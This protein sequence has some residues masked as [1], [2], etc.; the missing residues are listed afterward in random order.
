MNKIVLNVLAFFFVAFTTNAFSAELPANKFAKADQVKKGLFTVYV[1]GSNYFFEIPRRLMGRDFLLGS[2]IAE[3]SSVE[4]RSNLV[5]GQRLYDPIL[6]R[7]SE[8]V[9]KL[10]L[11]RPD[12]EKECA[13]EDP[14]FASFSLNNR[15][16]V[17]ETFDIEQRTDSSVFINVTKFFSDDLPAVE[18]FNEKSKP[19]KPILKLNGILRAES[20]PTNVEFTVRNA[21]ETTKEPFLVILQKS[22]IL[23]PEKPVMGRFSDE[24]MGYDVVNK[25]FYS[26]KK[27]VEKGSYITRFNLYPKDLKAYLRGELVE[28]VKPIVFYVD[29]SFPENWRKA[30]VKGIEDWQQAFEAVGF[31]N[32]IVARE[33]PK[34]PHF[35]PNDSRYN[36]FK[37]AV[38]NRSNAQGV[39]W[40]DPRSGEIVQAEVLFYSNI[41]ALLHKWYFL[42]TAAVN[43]AARKKELD[44]ETMEKLIRYSAAHEIGHCLGLTH[45]FRASF[46][47]D[48]EQLRN[49]AFTRKNGT[50]PSIMDYARFN[51]VAQPEDKKVSL[52]PP[53][54]GVYDL[55]AIKIGYQL[56][57]DA[58]TAT[59]DRAT[60]SKWL[61]E[62]DGDPLFTYGKLGSMGGVP[63]DPSRQSADLGNDP[64]ASSTYGIRNLRFILSHLTEWMQ[65]PGENYDDVS[66]MYDDILKENF[67]YLNNAIPMIGGVFTFQAV[68]GGKAPLY[69]CVDK[70]TSLR[71]ARFVISELCSEAAWLD[72]QEVRAFAGPQAEALIRSQ[73][74]T[75][76]K[77][78]DAGILKNLY[79]YAAEK[80]RLQVSDYIVQ[81][82]DALFAEKTPD[83]YVRNIQKAYLEKLKALSTGKK[84]AGTPYD[85]LL[86]PTVKTELS[87]LKERFSKS[88]DEWC[89]YLKEM[90]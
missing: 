48:T 7:F 41:T 77:L 57:P 8:D 79:W 87:R 25:E 38:C 82:S 76:E 23:L 20:F 26:S 2:R 85:C 80:N 16:P 28:P 33:Y 64:V 13:P 88:D 69:R 27:Q 49:P 71:T 46:A 40:T 66:Q 45:N 18:P 19:G 72:N 90:I 5:A 34:D 22:L 11:L 4:N 3:L 44:A 52:L 35:N 6:V 37:L 63:Q 9:D 51:Y 32:A 50:T 56:V 62:K 31:Q 65:V 1:K 55:F 36:C 14:F 58:K 81:I 29:S 61:L 78:L 68:A 43:P 12:P 39:H 24:R 83:L 75:V 74:E 10:L 30:I 15:V 17:A 89:S 53:V 86:I 59:E 21:Y 47:Y 70:E 60:V 54:L 73:T 42:Q 84:D 67:E